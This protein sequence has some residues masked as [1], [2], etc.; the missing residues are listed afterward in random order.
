[1]GAWNQSKR[2]GGRNRESSS[3]SSGEEAGGEGRREDED[4]VFTERSTITRCCARS[5]A[6]LVLSALR[7]VGYRCRASPGGCRWLSQVQS[8]LFAS[9]RVS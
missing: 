5:L 1:M 7:A 4:L 3:A 9:T 6:H 2:T 8:G